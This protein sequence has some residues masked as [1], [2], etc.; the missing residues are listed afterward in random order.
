MP[1]GSGGVPDPVERR[2]V[3]GPREGACE[4]LRKR[5]LD[6]HAVSDQLAGSRADRD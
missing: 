1:A 2:S 5:R 6:V 4:A 3:H